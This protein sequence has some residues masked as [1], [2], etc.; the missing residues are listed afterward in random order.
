MQMGRHAAL[1]F[2]AEHKCFWTNNNAVVLWPKTVASQDLLFE[3]ISA[4]DIVRDEFV[5]PN[6]NSLHPV[7][8]PLTS[9]KAPPS[10]RGVI[11]IKVFNKN[12]LSYYQTWLWSETESMHWTQLF[13]LFWHSQSI[14]LRNTKTQHLP[15]HFLNFIQPLA[16]SEVQRETIQLRARLTCRLREPS[17]SRLVAET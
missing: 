3:A 2:A 5:S 11:D 16:H 13:R 17:R 1:G 6:L 7:E 14:Q 9:I 8:R 15:L 4:N 12:S 10:F